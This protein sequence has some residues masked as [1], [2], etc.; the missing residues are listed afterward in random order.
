MQPRDGL[1]VQ[2]SLYATDRTHLITRVAD[3]LGNTGRGTSYGAELFA[4][5]HQ[6]PWLGWLSYVIN[7]PE[8]HR[9]GACLA[10]FAPAARFHELA[11]YRAE[12]EE[13]P[14]GFLAR[15]LAAL[16]LG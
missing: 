13:S 1:R 8:L 9:C 6:G 10:L 15:V 11:R 7:G 2:G 5:L 12:R 3:Q 16:G 14:P 4:T